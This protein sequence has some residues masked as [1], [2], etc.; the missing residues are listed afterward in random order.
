ML[1]TTWLPEMARGTRD[2]DLLGFG[3][4]SE[5]RILDIFR[6]I[7]AIAADDGVDFDLDALRVELIREELEYGGVRLRGAASLSGARIAVVVD[8]GFGDS[9]EP[10]LQTIDYS[11]LLDLPAPGSAPMPPRR[12]S[13][14][15]SRPWSPSAASTAG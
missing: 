2:L 6:E 13:P 14:R 1:L 10:G 12:L 15:N 8:I 11:S 4:P 7:L 3:D 5:Q 9:V